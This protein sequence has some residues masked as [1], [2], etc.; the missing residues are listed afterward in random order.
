MNNENNNPIVH[1]VTNDDEHS[2]HEIL[3][4][5]SSDI[6]PSLQDPSSSNN[7]WTVNP[8]MRVDS[9]IS[10]G[11]SFIENENEI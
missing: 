7:D 4:R 5:L 1:D 2:N 10:A 8:F 3:V 9:L 6:T 11:N